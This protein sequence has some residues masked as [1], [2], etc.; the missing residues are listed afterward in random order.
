MLRTPGTHVFIPCV[1]WRYEML[2]VETE[3]FKKYCHT[4][5]QYMLFYNVMSRGRVRFPTSWIHMV[6]DLLV[7]IKMWLVVTLNASFWGWTRK[8]HSCFSWNSFSEG[9]QTRQEV[10]PERLC[11]AAPVH[12][13]FWTPSWQPPHDCSLCTYVPAACTRD[14]SLTEL[15]PSSTPTKL[16]AK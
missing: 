1:V 3:F 15:L 5:F 16:W 14:C 4:S 7:A 12:S 2:T 13:T 8:K 11:L 10:W 9:I 6:H